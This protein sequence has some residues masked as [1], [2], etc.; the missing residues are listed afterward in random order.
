MYTVKAGKPIEKKESIK[1]IIIP[2]A[3]ADDINIDAIAEAHGIVVIC[4]SQTDEGV[5]ILGSCQVRLP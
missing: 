5:K 4:I 3:K 1:T 2:D